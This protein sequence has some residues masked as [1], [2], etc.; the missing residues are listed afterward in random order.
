[1]LWAIL[2]KSWRQHLTKQQLYG[3]LP[4]IL[5]AIK[6]RQTR[7]VG[8]CWKSN[9]TLISDVF[10]WTP[11]HSQ[12]KAGW[13]AW[14][15]IQQ[16]WVD[17]ECSL[18]DRPE[19]MDDREGWRERV[20]YIRADGTRWWWW[21]LC[22]SHL[23]FSVYALSASMRC[24]HT[25]KIDTTAAWKKSHSILLDKSDFHMIYNLSMAVDA[26]TRHK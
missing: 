6:I 14:T 23:A 19:V 22:S 5:K 11:S 1:M 15:Y 21:F 17:M 16:L 12:A 26:F 7:H 13:P 4:P 9:V 24:I 25:S 10:L 18:E 8:H 20:R 2:N 3:H